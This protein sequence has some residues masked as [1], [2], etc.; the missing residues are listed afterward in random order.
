M[1]FPGGKRRFL[2]D[3]LWV[4]PLLT[5]L[6]EKGVLESDEQ[7]H[8]RLRKVDREPRKRT[9]LSPQ[10]QRILER[11]QRAFSNVIQVEDDDLF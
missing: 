5:R 10:V 6:V 4:L 7:G 11:S 1:S 3:P 2:D 9:W 8:F